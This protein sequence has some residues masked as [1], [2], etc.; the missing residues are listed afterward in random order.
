M[1]QLEIKRTLD[2]RVVARRSDGQPLTEAD[3][4]QARRM[5]EADENPAAWVIEEVKD[6]ATGKT[7]AVKIC[8]APLESHLW[9]LN[10][11][12]FYPPDDDAVFF[13]D[14]LPTLNRK[15]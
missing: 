10:D 7:R 3:R 6:E 8:S 4:E 2:G 15:S 11:P 5:A 13:A 12:D 1:S 9:V 14:E